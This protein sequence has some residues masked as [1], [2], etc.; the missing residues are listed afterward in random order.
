[1]ESFWWGLPQIRAPVLLSGINPNG[2]YLAKGWFSR[3]ALSSRLQDWTLVWPPAIFREGANLEPKSGRRLLTFRSC[4]RKICHRDRFPANCAAFFGTP[5]FINL[6]CLHK[7]E[8]LPF[9]VKRLNLT[10]K[11]KKDLVV[12]DLMSW[13]GW[14]AEDTVRDV[15]ARSELPVLLLLLLLLVQFQTSQNQEVTSDHFGLIPFFGRATKNMG[16]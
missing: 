9:P 2:H 13:A 4:S 5:D 15:S 7:L 12:Y 10:K 3:R 1:M 6:R 11:W 8:W 16:R 14:L